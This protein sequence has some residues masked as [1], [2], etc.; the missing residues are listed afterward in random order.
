MLTRN[1]QRFSH[2]VQRGEAVPSKAL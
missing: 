2:P 1:P